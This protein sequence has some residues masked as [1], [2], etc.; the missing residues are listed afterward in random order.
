MATIKPQRPTWIPGAPIQIKE[1]TTITAPPDDIWRVLA[2]NSTWP[3]WF[4]GFTRCGFTS[5]EPHG[6]G[7]IRELKQD[8]FSVTEEI[9]L[10]KPNETW[11][12]TVT[13]I[14]PGLLQGMAE[15][16][17]LIENGTD[18]TIEWHIGIEPKWWAKPISR[19]LIKTAA[20]N[21]QTALLNLDNYL[22]HNTT[23]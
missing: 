5:A 20:E 7:S 12:M 23:T 16:V 15:A 8:Q 9:T 14:K 10:W 17:H 2:D 13:Q 19:P 11:G 1:T 6:V 21:L 3:D 22:Q 4:P 18:T